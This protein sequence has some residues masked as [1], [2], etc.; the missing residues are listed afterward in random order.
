MNDIRQEVV[1]AA[2]NKAYS[3]SDPTINDLDKQF[4][5]RKKIA[6]ADES[7]TEDEKS[8]IIKLFNEEYDTQLENV[9]STNESWFEESKAHLT[10]ITNG[11]I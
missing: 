6:L 4:E 5:F 3:L 2:F 1:W 8:V 10:I 9:K 11:Q 7:L